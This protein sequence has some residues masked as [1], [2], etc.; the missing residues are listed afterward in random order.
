MQGGLSIYA[1]VDLKRVFLRQNAA[2][3]KGAPFLGSTGGK[4]KDSVC[5]R[6]RNMD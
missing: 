4:R 2:K 6:M 5:M 3:S 1:P